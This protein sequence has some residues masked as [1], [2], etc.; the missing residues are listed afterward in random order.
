VADRP[1]SL[2]P[3]MPDEALSPDDAN[4][5]FVRR[6]AVARKAYADLLQVAG[7][8]S[9]P[10]FIQTGPVRRHR[11]ESAQWDADQLVKHAQQIVDELAAIHA[12]WDRVEEDNRG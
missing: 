5:E 12:L 3:D 10:L 11:V 9:H 8:L 2:V 1:L 7:R 6:W 4:L